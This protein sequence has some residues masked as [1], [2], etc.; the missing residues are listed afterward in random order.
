[1][2][3]VDRLRSG[4]EAAMRELYDRYADHVYAVA[5]KIVNDTALAQQILQ[6]TF[7]KAWQRAETYS[8]SKG[9]LVAWVIAIARHKAI[10]VLRSRAYRDSARMVPLSTEL[11][12]PARPEQ[13]K[14]DVRTTVANL[15]AKQREIIE[16]IYFRGY[17]HEEAAKAL[18]LPLGTVKGR[19][20]HAL[21]NL[22]K[23]L[24]YEHEH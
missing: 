13:R 16:L 10:D 4:D 8:A 24:K 20:R 5:L 6:D 21:H 17:T 18:K 22:R 23:A 3:L 19:I 1:M 15:S 7:V 2:A 12:N 14:P 9:R 11:P